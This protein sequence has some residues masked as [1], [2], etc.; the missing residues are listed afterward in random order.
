M[1]EQSESLGVA[2]TSFLDGCFHEL[3]A[4]RRNVGSLFGSIWFDWLAPI[5]CGCAV[6]NYWPP[7]PR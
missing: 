7:T 1:R 6:A 5:L 3:N 4:V 2:S